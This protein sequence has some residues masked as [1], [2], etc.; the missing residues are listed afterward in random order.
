MCGPSSGCV[1][2]HS[3]PS[4]APK[5]SHSLSLSPRTHPLFSCG[6]PKTEGVPPPAVAA[7]AALAA[8]VVAY[9][10]R[11]ALGAHR[12][13][14]GARVADGAL[15]LIGHARAVLPNLH[16]IHDWVAGQ[17]QLAVARA[18]GREGAT[19]WFTL[20]LMPAFVAV[21]HPAV[22]EHILKNNA[23]NYVKGAPFRDNFGPLLGRGI[24][25]ADGDEWRWQRKQ[26][27]RIFS[28]AG[29]RRYVADAFADRADALLKRLARAAAG[30]GGGGGGA[31]DAAAGAAASKGAAA[32]DLHDL[33]YRFT[34]DTFGRIGFGARLGCLEAHERIAFAVAFDRAQ[35]T[36]NARF[37]TPC[38]RLLELLV[39]GGEA[40]RGGGA[41]GKGILPS[42]LLNFDPR[43]LNN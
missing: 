39:R 15:P 26:A 4:C 28:V 37:W 17:S 29:F 13:P 6:A 25:V 21:S 20:P 14:R 22:L 18:G 7:A 40:R 43:T 5:N 33:M 1:Q 23:P 32:V 27:A 42:T 11:H 34:L 30:D 24:F 31:S 9:H 3:P 35:R 38:W 16:R 2:Q 41:R 12:P 10:W 19:F 8:A 36:T